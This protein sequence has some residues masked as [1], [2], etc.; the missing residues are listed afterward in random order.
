MFAVLAED[1]SDADALV[2]LVKSITGRTNLKVHKK[3]FGGC[4]QLCRK[5][6]SYIKLFADQGATR[7]VICHDSDGLDPRDIR[8]KVEAVIKTKG[9]SSYKHAVVVPVEEIEAW[10][11]ADEDAITAVIPSL[12]I[13]AVKKP[14]SIQSPKEW[15]VRESNKGR[16]TPLYVPA[17][18]N[19]QV[20]AHINLAKL[21]KKCPS[22]VLLKHFVNS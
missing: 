7:F 3:G 4:G 10:M 19:A 14:E 13:K 6:P 5:A 15:L 18:H 22:F 12:K 8:A 2:A 9:C 17:I 21:E 20:A 11:I 16:S 1:P